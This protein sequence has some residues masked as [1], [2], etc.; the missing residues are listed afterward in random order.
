MLGRSGGDDF[1]IVLGRPDSPQMPAE[2]A[3]AILEALRDP[4]HIEGHDLR[5]TASMGVALYPGDGRDFDTLLQK[6]DTALFV[7][8]ASGR[9]HFRFVDA[10][11]NAA[12]A[13]AL[14]MRAELA[15][16]LQRGEFELHYQPQVDLREGTVLGAEA[17]LRWRSPRRGLVAPGAF[18]HVAEDSGLIVPIGAWVLHQACRQAAAWRA[19]GLELMVGVNLSALQFRRGDLLAT[20]T[21]ALHAAALPP[22]LLELELTES[23]LLEDTEQACE[24]IQQLKRHGVRFALDDFGTGY[25]NL[26]SLQRFALDRLKIDQSFIR[27]IS[28]VPA[29][30]RIAGSI[31]DIGHAR[32]L[33]VIAEGVED[34]ETA[35]L[36][37]SANCDHA[38]GYLFARPL[39]AEEFLG[40]MARFEKPHGNLA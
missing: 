38:Q 22:E 5:V 8:K 19:G 37:R 9:D 32:G 21:D 20:V 12:A 18:I 29:E 24:V 2:R 25:S 27:N 26:S 36:L 11:S 16:A 7:A 40:W 33:E 30:A 23:L 34:D 10:A 4:F 31:I 14:S 39:P 17:L 3:S 13:D 15:M 28:S 1:L 6:A 35:E